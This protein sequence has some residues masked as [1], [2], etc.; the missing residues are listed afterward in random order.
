MCGYAGAIYPEQYSFDKE[1]ATRNVNW[2]GGCQCRGMGDINLEVMGE[3]GEVK[4][5]PKLEDAENPASD[6]MYGRV[7]EMDKVPLRRRW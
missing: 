2:G 4:Y 1:E 3:Y 6:M 5:S 7:V